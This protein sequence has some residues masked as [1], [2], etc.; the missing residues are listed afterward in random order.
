[1]ALPGSGMPLGVSEE[2]TW[3]QGS[4]EISPGSMLLLYTDGVLDTQDQYGEFLG[5]EGMLDIIQ[6]QMGKSAREVQDALL[7]GV[8][9]FAGSEPQVDDITLMVLI[10]DQHAR[11]L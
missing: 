8:Y 4:Q 6:T 7:S 5:E 2:A 1:M 3:Q 10:R 9:N 11:A